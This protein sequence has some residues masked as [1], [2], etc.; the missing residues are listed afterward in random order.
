MNRFLSALLYLVATLGSLSLMAQVETAEVENQEEQEEQVEEVVTIGTQ[1]RGAD[2]TDILPVAVIDE[3][4]IEALGVDSGDELLDALPE[5]GQN[6]F[7]EEENISGG[8]NSARGDVGAFNLRNLGT[9]N[10]L[11]LLNGRRMVNAASYQT[12]EVGGSFVPVNTVNSN[13]I[14]VFGV[15]RVELL[16]DGASAIYGADA[17]AGVVNSVLKDDID[18]FRVRTR[19]GF[20]ENVSRKTH[21][22][23]VEWGRDFNDGR[24]NVAFLMDMQNRDPIHSS[25]DEKWANSDFRRLIPEGSPWEGSISFR[26]NSAHSL[27]GQ[28]DVVSSVRNLDIRNTLVDT[29][30]EFETYPAGHENCAWQINENTCAARDGQGTYRYNLN[31]FRDVSSKRERNTMFLFINHEYESGL[32]SFSEFMYYTADSQISRHPSYSFSSIKLRVDAVNYYNPFGP[33]GSPNRLPE[34]VIGDVP[35]DGLTLEIDFYRYA[36][37]PRIVNA[38]GDSFRLL[39][40]WRGVQGK[41]DWETAALYSEASNADVTNN[42]V[43]NTLIVEALSDPTPAAYNPFNGGIDSNIERALIDV[44]RDS[45]ATLFLADVKASTPDL[46]SIGGR[47][48][49]GIFG[50]EVRRESF[51]DDRDPRLD[52]TIVFTDFQGDTYPYVSDVVNSSPTPD[53]SGDRVVASLFGEVQM[54]ITDDIDTQAA[55]RYENFSDVED[56]VVGKVAAG[57]RITDQLLVRGSWSQSFRAPN[58]VTI[59]EE[60]VA[61]QNTRT[62]WACRYAAEFGGDPDED[63]IDC[64]NSIQRVAQG[65][66]NLS[67]ETSQNSSIGVV[68]EPIDELVVTLDYWTIDKEDT[69]GLF[70]EENHTLWDLYLRLQHGNAN[71]ASFDPNPAITR[72]DY[73]D[74]AMAVYN[75]AGIC[76][77]GEAVRVE[78][79]YANLDRRILNGLDFSIYHKASGNW[80]R[81]NSQLLLSQA[82]KFEQEASGRAAT[83]VEAQRSGM[84][85]LNFPITGFEDLIQKNGNQELKTTLITSWRKGNLGISATFLYLGDFYQQSLTLADGTKYWVGDHMRT[86]LRFEYYRELADGVDSRWRLGIMNAT[87]ERAPL[88]DRY[89]GFFA[90]AH[91]DYGR[92]YYVDLR[93]SFD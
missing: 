38:D 82:L 20:Y 28:Y 80:G 19:L 41:W 36:E 4:V 85:P 44:R 57:W 78:D 59:N 71:C 24:T 33:C 13:H 10:T 15:R 63:I 55:L 3:E 48:V 66:K 75:A 29:A 8:V 14:P 72:I 5:Q 60:I 73:D 92:Y 25:E 47:N 91:R 79:Q 17:V 51:E 65:S 18:R 62:D 64:T 2:V 22:L 11:V 43:S 56:T 21:E 49:A 31:E 12:E 39:Q 7:N 54:A 37:L 27:Y 89:F 84:I 88:A 77:A 70:G 30:G 67:P 69:I 45:K 1:I 81:L 34:E 16:K 50:A 76:P 53:N 90:D 83:L 40:G 23:N 93:L 6:F 35:C 52:G 86:N 46:F 74:D 58:L 42:R 9:G 68:I 61:R 87:N 32:E 26:N